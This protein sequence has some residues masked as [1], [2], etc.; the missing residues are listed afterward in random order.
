LGLRGQFAL[1]FQF[2]GLGKLGQQFGFPGL[3]AAIAKH[4]PLTGPQPQHTASML[5]I[6]QRKFGPILIHLPKKHRMHA[7][8]YAYF[9]GIMLGAYSRFHL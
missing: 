4:N 5:P 8:K 6:G 7:Q 9:L 1:N 2:P 3:S